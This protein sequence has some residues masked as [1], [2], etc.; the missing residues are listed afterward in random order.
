MLKSKFNRKL[1]YAVLKTKD[2]WLNLTL[3]LAYE[4]V[5]VVFHSFYITFS[6]IFNLFKFLDKKLISIN[7]FLFRKLFIGVK[8]EVIRE[9]VE[10]AKKQK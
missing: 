8:I 2:F 10:N 3:F 6:L 4:L 1:F 7:S 5:F 9:W